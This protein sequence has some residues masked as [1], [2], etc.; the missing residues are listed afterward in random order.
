[1]LMLIYIGAAEPLYS[2]S[3]FSPTIIAALG[4]WTVPQSL[5]LSTPRRSFFGLIRSCTDYSLC[6]LLHLDPRDSVVLGPI[7]S[8]RLP[9]D[10]LVC[11]P[12]QNK[13]KH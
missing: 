7:P 1:M 6:L 11:P 9:V 2:G 13:G 5:L 4:K 8:A 12:P 10:V 3:L